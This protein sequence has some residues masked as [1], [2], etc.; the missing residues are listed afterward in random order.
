M[1]TA[2]LLPTQKYRNHPC[3]V[4]MGGGGEEQTGETQSRRIEWSE[5]IKQM[6]R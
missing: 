2:G 5:V 6:R 4:F 1:K 3:G